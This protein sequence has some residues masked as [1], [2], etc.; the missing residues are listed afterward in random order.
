[1]KIAGVVCDVVRVDD[2]EL[3]EQ[4]EEVH[5]R[6]ESPRERAVGSERERLPVY[7]RC[8]DADLRERA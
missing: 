6:A 5:E 8:A 4:A 1:V 2:E 7:E 3:V